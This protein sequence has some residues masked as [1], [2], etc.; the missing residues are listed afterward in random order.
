VNR[1][2]VIAVEDLNVKALAGG[3]LAMSV[4]D[5]GWSMFLNSISYKAEWAGREFRKVDPRGTSQM[6]P[7]GARV[8]KGLNDR[9]HDC[10]TCGLSA[11]RDHVS[12]QIILKR[13]R[14]GPSGVNVE[15]VSSCVA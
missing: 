6:C 13:G 12:A 8:P 1:F 9:W 14:N 15:S 5:A 11:G 3:M 10:R 7:C 2:G 4:H